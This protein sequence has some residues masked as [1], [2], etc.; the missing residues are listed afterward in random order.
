[1]AVTRKQFDAYARRNKQ[2]DA[3]V[4]RAI[5]SIWGKLDTSSMESLLLD[6]SIYLPLI[7][8]KFG[9]VSATVAAEFYDASRKASKAKGSYTATTAT[10]ATWKID[11]DIK[12]ATGGEFAGDIKSFLTS[13]VQGVV[14]DYGRQ[15]IAE[16]SDADSWSDGYT[17]MPT[18]DNPC[19]F[20]QIKSMAS[21]WNYDGGKL[22]EEITEDA[23]HDNCSCELVP[24]FRDHPSW[25]VERCKGYE[26]NYYDAANLIRSGD[27]PE[28]LQARIDAAK[29]QHAKLVAEGKSDK[30]WSSFNEITIAMRYQNEGMH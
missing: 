25:M 23:W 20:C 1:M 3:G 30:K 8:E 29:E 7:A 4:K 6:L 14:H 18:S 27:V 15:T 17:S 10:A 9:A 21:M 11:R 16:N 13:T 5:D 2:I 24:T 26:D 28:D 12:Y 19:A 22:E